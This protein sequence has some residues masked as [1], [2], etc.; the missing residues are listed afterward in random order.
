[1]ISKFNKKS[2]FN[3]KSYFNFTNKWRKIDIQ[4]I[5]WR[6]PFP[7]NLY[8]GE[9]N[10]E[11]TSDQG[12]VLEALSEAFTYAFDMKTGNFGGGI[13]FDLTYEKNITETFGPVG[14]QVTYSIPD[15]VNAIINSGETFQSQTASIFTSEESYQNAFNACVEGEG[16]FLSFSVAA[17]LSTESASQTLSSGSN[18]FALTTGGQVMFTCDWSTLSQPVNSDFS[19]AWQALP[20]QLISTQDYLQFLSFFQNYG[21]HFLSSGTFGGYYAVQASGSSSGLTTASEAAIS[22]AIEL[23]FEGVA[24]SGSLSIQASTSSQQSGSSSSDIQSMSLFTRGGIFSENLETFLQS[25][26]AQPIL[27]IVPGASVASF[28]PLSALFPGSATAAAF[29]LALSFYLLTNT[30]DNMLVAVGNGITPATGVAYNAFSDGILVVNIAITASGNSPIPAGAYQVVE[31]QTDSSSVPTTLRAA[32]ETTGATILTSSV[33]TPVRKGDYYYIFYSSSTGAIPSSNTNPEPTPGATLTITPTF[34]PIA[35][36]YG[37]GLGGWT[38]Q[39]TCQGSCTFSNTPTSDTFWVFMLQ[40]NTANSYANVGITLTPPS[41]SSISLGGASI[42][43]P[44]AGVVLSVASACIPVPANWT[45]TY[46]MTISGTA[47]IQPYTITIGTSGTLGAYQSLA[48]GTITQS[49]L[50]GILL[51]ASNSSAS[52]GATGLLTLSANSSPVAATSTSVWTAN[53]EITLNMPYATTYVPISFNIPVSWSSSVSD[54]AV[55]SAYWL[56][57]ASP[58]T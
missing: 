37:G 58:S 27:L 7:S 45:I 33:V 3:K 50:G 9:L 46:D 39:A 11:N 17:S 38:Q 21:T 30:N 29:D 57:F 14:S 54:G 13:V 25:I 19:A 2:C 36:Q 18:Y 22:G 51:G 26:Y 20:T 23:A 41:G 52:N 16:A 6:E 53:N 8:Y 4:T 15:Q 55:S 10:M 40:S 49:G 28:T 43:N 5:I 31:I 1:V 56:P 24:S 48:A 12:D 32:A 42:F 44:S 47:T 35:L 34:Y